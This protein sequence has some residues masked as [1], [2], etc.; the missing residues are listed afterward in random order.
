[1]ACRCG[2]YRDMLEDVVNTLDLSDG[3][4]AEHGPLGTGR[5]TL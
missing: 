2:E 5:P 4:I 1:M 3:M